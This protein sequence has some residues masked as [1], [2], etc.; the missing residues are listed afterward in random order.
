MKQIFQSLEN[1]ETLISE[2]PIPSLKNG[3]LLIKSSCSLISTGTERMLISFGKSNL[4]D[5]AKGQPEKVKDVLQKLKSDGPITTYQAVKNKLEQPIPLG[6][7]NVGEIIEI[8]NG[9]EGFN[10][11]D[12]VIS[13]GPHAEII[14]VPKNLCAL[15]PDNLNDVEAAFT[16][17]ASIGLQG[18]RL[19]KPTF[20]E[21]FLVIG[22]GLIGNL[23]AQLLK[24][25]GCKVIGFDTDKNKCKLARELGIETIPIEGNIDP[26]SHCL[27]LTKNVG[28][29]GVII[30]ASTNSDDPIDIASKACRKRGRIILIGVTGLNLKRELFYEK[31]I[32]FR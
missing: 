29:D 14:S 5:K 25:Q 15:V 30:A 1:G 24:S 21:V 9:V 19:L 20:G 4:I 31:E 12:R 32:S 8:G 22:L 7:C 2:I 26:I 18:I 27:K 28:V 17:P 3:H 23:T 6:Y 11:G 10:I 13:N 16:V